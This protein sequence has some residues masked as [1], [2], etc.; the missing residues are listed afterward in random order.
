SWIHGLKY[1][2]GVH[3]YIN[4][5]LLHNRRAFDHHI[6]QGA[7]L[8]EREVSASDAAERI[9]LKGDPSADGDMAIHANAQRQGAILPGIYLKNVS[10][11]RDGYILA[12][13]ERAELPVFP[14][15]RVAIVVVKF[16]AG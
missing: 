4:A 12:P 10:L 6:G 2:V 11:Q 7:L 3:E 14:Q 8:G 9:V 15:G 16:A 13:A 5:L 1:C